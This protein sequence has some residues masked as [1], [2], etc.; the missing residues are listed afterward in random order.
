M[1]LL[2]KCQKHD[3]QEIEDVPYDVSALEEAG[4]L[5]WEQIFRTPE[6][7]SVR[8]LSSWRSYKSTNFKIEVEI[9]G[10]VESPSYSPIRDY[11]SEDTPSDSE[12]L[13]S[14]DSSGTDTLP[15][16]GS[17]LTGRRVN[18][19]YRDNTNLEPLNITLPTRPKV[20]ATH[21]SGL[22]AT[23]ATMSKSHRNPRLHT[24]L[25]CPFPACRRFKEPFLKQARLD[26]HIRK[27]HPITQLQEAAVETTRTEEV[28]S[29]AIEAEVANRSYNTNH[30]INIEPAH[31]TAQSCSTYSTLVQSEGQL[32]VRGGRYDVQT[33][34]GHP[35][36]QN[37]QL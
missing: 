30:S 15:M 27:Y 33:K 9:E 19:T 4:R 3:L 14:D 2:R 31:T 22:G 24:S 26:T 11:S 1:S 35:Q 21:N 23:F 10:H 16:I 28:Q 13:D 32:V 18:A 5:L 25:C 20:N 7:D 6:S 17:T 37:E 34:L 8:R 12:S 29:G 36:V